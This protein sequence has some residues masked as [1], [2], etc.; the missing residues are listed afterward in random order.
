M[1]LVFLSQGGE[2]DA[3]LVTTVKALETSIREARTGWDVSQ[4][5][6]SQTFLLFLLRSYLPFQF[7]PHPKTNSG[8]VDR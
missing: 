3:S 1:R 2:S 6:P 7:R 4:Q 5:H 8:H